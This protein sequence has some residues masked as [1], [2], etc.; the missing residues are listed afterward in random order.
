[1]PV[2]RACGA[3]SPDDARFCPTCGSMF[4]PAAAPTGT[5][6]VPG[7]P[8][9]PPPLP[10][11]PPLPGPT[12]TLPPGRPTGVTIL[13]VWSLVAG[14]L[15]GLF[16][17]AF[18]ALGPSIINDPQFQEQ[19]TAQQGPLSTDF[20]AGAF[21][22]GGV[23]LFLLGAAM[24]VAGYGALQRKPWGWTAMMVVTGAW[25]LFSLL[26]FPG[27]LFLLI[28]AGG[29]FWYLTRDGV[30]AWFGRGQA[31]EPGLPGYVPPPPG[32]PS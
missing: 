13:G 26:T 29:A 16:G 23:V 31:S 20:L 27:G 32:P 11:A 4:Q 7:G 2:C 9:P 10:Y 1:M 21:V 18:A 6:Y 30:K 3:T 22:V 12:M 19:I 15:L 25:A 5:A 14:P 24:G 17:L 8:A 28:L